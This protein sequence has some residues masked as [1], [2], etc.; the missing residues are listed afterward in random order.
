MLN[1]LAGG[2][3]VSGPA[4]AE[5]LAVSRTRI[6]QIVEGLRQ[7]GYTIRS[8]PG[9]GYQWI[10]RFQPLDA[11]LIGSELPAGW[12]LAAH[13][14]IDSTSN[15]IA[16]ERPHRGILFSEHQSAGRGRVGRVWSSPPGGLYFSAGR[17]YSDL[18][19]GPQSLSPWIAA[20]LVT[21]LREIG[22]SRVSAKWPNDL[23]LDGAKLGGVL[24]EL[25]GDP[26]GDCHVCV[27]VGINWQTPPIEEQPVAGIRGA[28]PDAIGRNQ[29]AA[30]AAAAVAGAL[31]DYP[32]RDGN[33]V[34]DA[35]RAVDVSRG[36]IVACRYADQT[37]TGRAD[38]IESDG[39]LRLI[40]HDGVARF[41]AGEL[42][43]DAQG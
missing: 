41:A 3:P 38:G 40:T 28:A 11:A 16:L 34:V 22:I 13:W 31:D 2:T 20:C 6:W 42:H 43:L 4:L 32:Q 29:V 36:R 9:R 37:L 14:E 26:Y 17:W 30:R 12:S 1:A 35:W 23:I 10:N 15:R 18:S 24:I 7:R 33:S 39:A 27:G 19:A 21:A 25:A 5:E 8:L